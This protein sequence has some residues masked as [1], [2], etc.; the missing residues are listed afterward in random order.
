[1]HD[2]FFRGKRDRRALFLVAVL[3][4]GVLLK[5]FPVDGFYELGMSALTGQ[6][7]AL[8]VAG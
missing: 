8:H 4:W 3:F 2:L 1:M 6:L 7:V 5:A